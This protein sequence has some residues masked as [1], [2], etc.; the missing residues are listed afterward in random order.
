MEDESEDPEP[1]IPELRRS[2]S[3]YESVGMTHVEDME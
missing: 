2:M 1:Y 3:F